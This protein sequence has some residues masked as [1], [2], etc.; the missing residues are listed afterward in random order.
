MIYLPRKWARW[1]WYSSIEKELNSLDFLGNKPSWIQLIFLAIKQAQLSWFFS[2]EN[3]LNLVDFL[4]DKAGW[5]QFFC[6][7]VNFQ[8]TKMRSNKLIFQPRK[9]AEFNRFACQENELNAVD[10]HGKKTSE[11]KSVDFPAKNMSSQNLIFQP[12]KWAQISWFSC[13]ENELK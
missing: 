3:E 13:H 1:S 10:F 11:L 8:V 12:R 4:G 9:R 5:I 7:S 6:K 2:Q